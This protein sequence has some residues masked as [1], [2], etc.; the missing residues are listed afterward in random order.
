MTIVSI[1]RWII[2]FTHRWP[3]NILVVEDLKPLLMAPFVSYKL[4]DRL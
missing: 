2:T 1:S 4:I 3:D